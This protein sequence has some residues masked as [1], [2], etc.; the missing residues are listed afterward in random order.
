M[1]F[2]AILAGVASLLAAVQPA[3]AQAAPPTPTEKKEATTLVLP[4]SPQT[5]L[6]DRFAGWKAAAPPK[7]VSDPGNVDPANAVALQEY[8]FIGAATATYKRAGETLTLLALRFGD[9]SGAYG[10]YSLY[11]QNGWPRA[12]IGAG[13]ASD[14]NRVL[15]W[16]GTTVVDARFSAVS[17]TSAGELRELAQRLPVPNGNR[18]LMPPVLG[19]LPQASMDKQTTHY[20]VGPAGYAGS[21]GVL[22]PALAGFDRGAEVAMANYSLLSG[23]ATLTIIDFPTPEMARGAEKQIGDYLKAGAQAQPPWPKPLQD[24]DHSSLAVRS[25]GPL[26][27]V[28]SGAAPSDESQK[29]LDSVYYSANLTTIP[30]A[31]ESEVAKTGQLLL[32]IAEL[33]LI[34]AIGAVLLGFFLGGGRALYRLAR[35]RPVSSVFDEEFIRLD[36]R[37]EWVEIP[38][39]NGEPHPK[40]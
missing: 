18:S 4:P 20:A 14:H 17:P 8:G 13:A 22:P 25:T 26:V 16:K 38:P 1:R 6:P 10:A 5:L 28:V 31:K 21:G 7:S 15:F 40:G 27:A 33:S 36:L 30:G 2:V 11:R 3:C 24:S 39:V 12:D 32:G 34:G 37:D 9:S 35:G 29:L 23:P 19:F